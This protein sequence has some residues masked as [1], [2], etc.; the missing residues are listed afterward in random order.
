MND[1]RRRYNGPPDDDRVYWL[2][3]DRDA[4]DTSWDNY[5]ARHPER[6]PSRS[7]AGWPD[8]NDEGTAVE[9]INVPPGTQVPF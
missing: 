4:L 2:P 5:F 6:D 7:G 1:A 3:R 8:G 9:P